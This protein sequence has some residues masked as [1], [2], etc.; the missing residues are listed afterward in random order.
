LQS[1]MNELPSQICVAKRRPQFC[2]HGIIRVYL[3]GAALPFAA[4]IGSRDDRMP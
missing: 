4:A 3:N 1:G 2:G